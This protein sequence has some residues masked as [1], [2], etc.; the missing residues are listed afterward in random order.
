LKHIAITA[1][2][3]L[4]PWVGV[5]A[6]IYDM[7]RLLSEPHPFA[8]PP[9][10]PS[11]AARPVPV[12][13]AAPPVVSAPPVSAPAARPPALAPMRGDEFLSEVRL[14]VLAH[15]QG[16]FSSNK[17]D[18][19][20]INLELLFVSPDFLDGI[21]A[22]RPHAGLTLNTSGDTSQA[23]LGLSWEWDFWDG[24]FAGFSLGGAVHNGE[25]LRAPLDKKELGCSVLFRESIDFGYRL[26]DNNSLMVHLGHISNAKLCDTNEGLENIGI[27]HGY[28]F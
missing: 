26:D 25:T 23:Y 6:A 11:A 20:D 28:R 9:A 22:P 5:Q 2:I 13:S 1:V 8:V 15:D 24:A 12:P 18:G 27:R 16:P 19:A 3:V 7:D 10:A 14:G 4:A 21:G 17:E